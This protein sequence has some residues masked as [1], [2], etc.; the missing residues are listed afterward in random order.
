MK[1]NNRKSI[2]FLF[3]INYVLNLNLLIYMIALYIN[4]KII[5]KNRE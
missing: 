5:I 2:L 4:Q 3:N 1:L